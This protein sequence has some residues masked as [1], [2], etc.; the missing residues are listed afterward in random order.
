AND[1]DATANDDDATANDD[2]ATAN[3][4]DATAND[5]DATADDDDATADDDD[6]SPPACADAALETALTSLAVWPQQNA[7]A[8][9]FSTASTDNDFRLGMSLQIPEESTLAVGDSFVLALDGTEPAN[10]VPG[11]LEVQAGVRLNNF[12]CN[13]AIV[14]GDEPA[15][16]QQWDAVDGTATV[17]VDQ[18]NGEAW[19]GGPMTFTATVSVSGVVVEL[20]SAP[21][22]TCLVPDASWANQS[23]GWL[24]G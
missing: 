5:D 7:C 19:P 8:Y 6:D 1:D 22:S 3:D 24:P 12:D 2:D 11:T 15:V 21:G 10:V 9:F 18:L 16:S 13:D 17:V 23:M 14:P 20:D 4:D